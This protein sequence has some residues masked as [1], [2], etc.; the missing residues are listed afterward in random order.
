MLFLKRD[1]VCLN[2]TRVDRL[3]DVHI[4][5]PWQESE[6]RF[7]LGRRVGGAGSVLRYGVGAGVE[8]ARVLRHLGSVATGVDVGANRGQLA[9]AARHCFPDVR[10]TSFEPLAGTAERAVCGRDRSRRR[11][12]PGS[13]VGGGAEHYRAL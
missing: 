2:T 6:D 11:L 10:V 3:L 9:L 1:R 7:A 8:H 5:H 12:H 4:E 13:V